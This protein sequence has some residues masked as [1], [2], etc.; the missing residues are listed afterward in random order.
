MYV[1][2]SLYLN[3]LPIAVED[4]HHP[5]LLIKIDKMANNY[6]NISTNRKQK[7]YNFRLINWNYLE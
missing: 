1:Y 7:E 2:I 6:S 3:E 4:V 5:C